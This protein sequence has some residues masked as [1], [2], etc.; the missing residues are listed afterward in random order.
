MM[1]EIIERV[2]KE[3]PVKANWY[4]PETRKGILL[5]DASSIATGI[6]LEIAIS[7]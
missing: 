4:V 5:C 3:D 2:K 1:K 6:L 7:V